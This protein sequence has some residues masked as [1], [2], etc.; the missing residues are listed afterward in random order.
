MYCKKCGAHLKDLARFCDKCGTQVKNPVTTE[1]KVEHLQ[2]GIPSQEQESTFTPDISV[3]SEDVVRNSCPISDP[4]AQTM[5]IKPVQQIEPDMVNTA[6]TQ[7]IPQVPGEQMYRAPYEQRY[8]EKMIPK[9]T[10]KKSALNVVVAVFLILTMGLVLIS[11]A[12]FSVMPMYEVSVD[13]SADEREHES[14]VSALLRYESARVPVS[15]ELTV[16]EL[17]G[18]RINAVDFL[19]PDTDDIYGYVA[20]GLIALCVL[21][22]LLLIIP[23]ALKKLYV[24]FCLLAVFSQVCL[25]VGAVVLLPLMGNIVGSAMDEFL[26]DFAQMLV[27]DKYVAIE[28]ASSVLFSTGGYV[29]LGLIGFSIIM[30][31]V[32]MTLGA[33]N[34]RKMQK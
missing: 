29:V 7:Y 19:H 8:P 9:S 30:T 25:L 14:E 12:V 27:F 11:S 22:T 21:T 17:T 20:I 15:E 10:Q 23:L 33:V 31:I 3:Q 16:F 18:K 24:P 5:E 1:E 4:N 28:G 13:I 32:T 34:V 2:V 26:V 6:P